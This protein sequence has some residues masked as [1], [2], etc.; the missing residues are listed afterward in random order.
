MTPEPTKAISSAGASNAAGS[1]GALPLSVSERAT[2]D[3][4]GVG[5][6]FHGCDLR[7]QGQS[8][9]TQS[10]DANNYRK[11]AISMTDC[12]SADSRKGMCRKDGKG[13]RNAK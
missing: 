8:A 5:L 11:I 4:L 9:H 1:P 7:I 12:H 10:S 3:V 2:I 6:E 13:V